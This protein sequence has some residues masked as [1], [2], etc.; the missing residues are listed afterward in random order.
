MT[1][2]TIVTEV[3]VVKV[4]TKT[5]MPQKLWQRKTLNLD[6]TQQLQLGQNS[7]TQNMTKLK[8]SICDKILKL[9]L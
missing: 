4:V 8:N 1:I 7:K 2:V 6:K 9:K 5:S 3:T